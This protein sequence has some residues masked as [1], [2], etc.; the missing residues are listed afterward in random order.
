MSESNATNGSIGYSSYQQKYPST[1]GFPANDLASII[2]FFSIIA[3]LFV[4]FVFYF[5]FTQWHKVPPQQRHEEELE[6]QKEVDLLVENLKQQAKTTF[7]IPFITLII[8]LWKKQQ[9]QAPMSHEYR[10]VFFHRFTHLFSIMFMTAMA[11]ALAIL[12]GTVSTPVASNTSSVLQSCL[13]VF[14]VCINL[15]FIT[16]QRFYYKDRKQLFG[17]D[18]AHINAVYKTQFKDWNPKMLSNWI[19]IAI[20]TIEFFQLLTFPLRD[21]ITVNSFD[22]GHGGEQT[23]FTHLVS[24]VMNAGGFM[25]DM[26]TPT[27]YTYSVW[28]A[29]AATIVS[30]IVAVVFHCVNLWRPYKLPTR[31]VRWCIPV[32]S[33]LYIPV[34]TTFV[35][36]AA[37][38][39]LNIPTHEYSENLRCHSSQISQQLYLWMSLIG[40]VLAYLLMTV[41]LTSYERIPQQNEI[42]FKS[43]SVA[44]IK[45]MGKYNI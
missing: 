35:S 19:Q 10:K 34:L 29:F 14:V 13:F 36:S 2:L 40:Y 28:T 32:A 44:F 7:K 22:E 5:W 21:L 42:A 25:P 6:H 9:Q 12:I 30:F 18:D 16:R 38:Q 17:E 37:C 15:F 41:F 27:W 33:L 1:A 31:W 23:K 3:L 20:L 45:N 43:V 24:L 8:V 11:I 39:S 26:R 4:S